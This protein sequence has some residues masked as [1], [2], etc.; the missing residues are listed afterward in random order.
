MD[1]RP[2]AGTTIW[3]PK[4][5]TD[6]SSQKR[7]SQGG[8]DVDQDWKTG[9]GAAQRVEHYELAAYGTTSEFAKILGESEH[10][11]LLEQPLQEETDEKLTELAKEINP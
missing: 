1:K 7:P 9:P 11:T 8:T 5:N 2:A 10:V 6:D 3:Q 4:Q